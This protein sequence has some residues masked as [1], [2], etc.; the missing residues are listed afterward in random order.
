M[1]SGVGLIARREF[2]ERGRSRVFIGVLIGSMVLILAGMFAVSLVGR[3]APSASVTVAGEGPAGLVDEVQRVAAD[4]G[5]DVVV[6]DSASVEQARQA[7]QSGSVD[8]AL[9]DGDTI[10][11]VGAPSSS[12]DAVL[13]GAAT[14]DRPR[15][16]RPAAGPV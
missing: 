9:I 8:A 11:A 13:R 6:V 14:A 10:V 7:V 2:V 1:S 4:L 5:V 3:P 12:V 16:G 15:R